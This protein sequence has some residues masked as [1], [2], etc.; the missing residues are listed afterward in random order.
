MQKTLQGPGGISIVLDSAQIFPDD[1]GAGTP[2]MVYFNPY[3]KE[4]S[5]TFYCALDTGEL[6]CGEHT[7]SITHC[8]WLAAQENTV[9]EFL[10]GKEG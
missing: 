2:A 10:D 6:E 4:Y 3:G 7:L 8:N 1:P 9:A 5:A